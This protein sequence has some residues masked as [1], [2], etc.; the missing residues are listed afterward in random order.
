MTEKPMRVEMEAYSIADKIVKPL[1]ETAGRVYLPASWVGK[2]VR[3]VLV[4]PA[5][6]TE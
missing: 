2:K 1:S 6:L 4:E 3:V 5:E